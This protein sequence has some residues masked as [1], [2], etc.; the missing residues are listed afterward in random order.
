MKARAKTAKT[1]SITAINWSFPVT[2]NEST[3][4]TLS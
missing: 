4:A 3:Q 1:F 2:L